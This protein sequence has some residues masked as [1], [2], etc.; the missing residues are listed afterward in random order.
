MIKEIESQ[1]KKKASYRINGYFSILLFFV[2]LVVAILMWKTIVKKWILISIPIL[3]ILLFMCLYIYIY[4]TLSKLY[5]KNKS[6]VVLRIDKSY[7]LFKEKQRENDIQEL[8]KILKENG[9]NTR[10]KVENIL[11]HYRVLI[12]RN[13]NEKVTVISILALL[14]SVLVFLY[15]SNLDIL[16]DK[17]LSLVVIGALTLIGCFIYFFYIKE[18]GSIFSKKTLYIRL[19]YL[20]TEI[21]IKSLIK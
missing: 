4:N 2:Y 9:V 16:Y 7:K 17:I 18:I 14:V 6:V 8:I 5:K 3:I 21:Y 13:V 19:E 11:N 10:K 15:G 1:F 20:L 12:P